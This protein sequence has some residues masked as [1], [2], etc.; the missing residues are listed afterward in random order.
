M[1][2]FF[3]RRISV[4]SKRL[5]APGMMSDLKCESIEKFGALDKRVGKDGRSSAWIATFLSSSLELLTL[6]APGDSLRRINVKVS[7]QIKG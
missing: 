4:W 1:F 6:D 2:S 5:V 3:A 7:T